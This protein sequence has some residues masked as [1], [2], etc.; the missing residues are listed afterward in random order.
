MLSFFCLYCVL[1][2]LSFVVKLMNKIIIEGSLVVFICD[3]IGNLI[4]EIIWFK[5]GE[6]VVKGKKLMFVINRN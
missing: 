5:D 6:I 2:V 3:V 4:L 1:D